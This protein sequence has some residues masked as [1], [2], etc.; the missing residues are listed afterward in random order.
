VG[1]AYDPGMT[2][3]VLRIASRLRQRDLAER[4][5]VSRET[6]IRVERS[7]G[8]PHRA[9]AQA[10]ALALGVDPSALFPGLYA[11]ATCGERRGQELDGK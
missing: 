9:T 5:G 11:D 3:R 10:I 1:Q 2:V 7:A 8:Q 6:V 4:A